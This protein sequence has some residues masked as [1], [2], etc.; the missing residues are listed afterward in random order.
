MKRVWQRSVLTAGYASFALTALV[1]VAWF[2]PAWLC[3]VFGHEVRGAT[4]RTTEREEGTCRHCDTP[5]T[6][7]VAA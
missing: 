1:A 3:A 5:V 4:W 2:R 7:E 6:R